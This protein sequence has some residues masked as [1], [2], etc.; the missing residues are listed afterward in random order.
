MRCQNDT[1]FPPGQSRRTQVASIFAEAIL[2]LHQRMALS[3]TEVQEKTETCLDLEPETV[4]SGAN[5]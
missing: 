4:L 3:S 2:R 5:G 1:N